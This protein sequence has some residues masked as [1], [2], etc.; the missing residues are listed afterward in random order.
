MKPK[1]N[2]DLKEDGATGV[3]PG[4][5]FQTPSS[6]PGETMD[7][8]SLAGP[9]GSASGKKKKKPTIKKLTSFK[10]FLKSR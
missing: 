10:D 7:T 5:G 4:T 6:L 8:M 9:G 1:K 3:S 2:L